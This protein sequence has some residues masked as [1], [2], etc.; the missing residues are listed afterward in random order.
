[1]ID[2]T[3]DKITGSAR[4]SHHMNG[5]RDNWSL[6]EQVLIDFHSENNSVEELI[7]KIRA[8]RCDSSIENCYN[9]LA[10]L[11]CRLLF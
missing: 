8:C 7:D 2:L 6:I 4:R 5:I 3:I 9:K 11:L 10:K 1:M